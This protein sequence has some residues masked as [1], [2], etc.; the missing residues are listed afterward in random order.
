MKKLYSL[1]FSLLCV[2]FLFSQERI[3]VAQSTRDVVILLD[4]TDGSV[5]NNDFIDLT[6]LGA[7]TPKDILQVGDE[8]WITDQIQDRIDR[9]D[10]T[11]TYVSTIEST[12]GLD[13]LRGLALVNGEVWVC[14]AGSNNGAPGNAIVRFDTDGNLL[15]NYPTANSPFDV[16]DTGTEAIISFINGDSIERFDYSGNSLSVITTSVDFPQQLQYDSTSGSLLVAGFSPPS[17]IYQFN[18]STGAQEYYLDLG[19]GLRGVIEL[20]NGTLLA[21][22]SSGLFTVDTTTNTFNNYNTENSQYFS[23]VDLT[24]LSVDDNTFSSFIMYPNPATNYLEISARNKFTTINVSNI[25][26]QKVLELNTDSNTERLDVSG[27]QSGVYLIV[28]SNGNES[29]VKKFIKK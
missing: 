11:G 22:S 12:V 18:V 4:P 21:S 25:L 2:S 13:N 15:G 7:S 5:I 20:D 6:T 8:L 24:P 19:S 3:A 14:N 23:K 9:F 1:I 29:V 17:G 10:L 16:I 28:V 26:G 27:L